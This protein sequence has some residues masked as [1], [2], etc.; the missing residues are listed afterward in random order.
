V[1]V[2]AFER[3]AEE[4]EAHGAPAN[5]IAS[6]RRAGRD[7]TRHAALMT[8]L[9]RTFDPSS[10]APIPAA[11]R[12]AVR[13]L[14]AIAKENAIEGCV[15]ET[16]GAALALLQAER[17]PRAETRA[18]LRSI[19][20]D[21]CRHAELSWRVAAWAMPRLE[22]A[23]RRAIACGVRA[24]VARLARARDSLSREARTASGMPTTRGRR[25]LVSRLDRRVFSSAFA[26]S[27]V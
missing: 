1:S 25:A 27:H 18:A 19:A 12:L 2:H 13:T 10:E 6:A 24:A 14:G 11:S 21:E 7:E 15:G 4:L 16:Y 9:A 23:E 5:L 8:R 17:A 26:A 22:S 20:R 3:L